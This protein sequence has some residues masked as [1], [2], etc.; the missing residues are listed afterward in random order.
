MLP[1]ND[2]GGSR[3]VLPPEVFCHVPAVMLRMVTDESEAARHR[4][5]AARVLVSMAGQNHGVRV[6][7]TVDPTPDETDTARTVR[8]LLEEPDYLEYLHWRE[9]AG[10]QAQSGPRGIV[11]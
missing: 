5:Q 10:Q 1:D 11:G 8:A 3:W 9:L 2:I 4:V 6:D 7:V